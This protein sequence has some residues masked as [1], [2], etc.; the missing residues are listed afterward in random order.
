MIINLSSE[1]FVI[2]ADNNG[3][4]RDSDSVLSKKHSIYPKPKMVDEVDHDGMYQSHTT[5]LN[6][7]LKCGA[8]IYEQQKSKREWR[9]YK[10]IVL[11]QKF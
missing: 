1:W 8:N 5:C 3:W 11:I 7:Q 4:K 10:N 6:M 9:R 2:K